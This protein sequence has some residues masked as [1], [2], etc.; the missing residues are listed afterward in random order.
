MVKVASLTPRLPQERRER[1]SE[2]RACDE[3]PSKPE[4]ISRTVEIEYSPQARAEGVEG[5]LVLRLT[6]AADG[7]VECVEVASGVHPALDAM[8]VA[9]VKQ[10]RFRPARACGRPVGGGIYTLAR[11]FELVD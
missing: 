10:W 9:A 7:T 4:P 6:I 1:P 5:R 3:L 8:A 11:K 2:E